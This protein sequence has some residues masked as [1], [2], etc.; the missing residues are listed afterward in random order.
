M[1]MTSTV[2]S[3]ASAL[4]IE[5]LDMIHEPVRHLMPIEAMLADPR[6]RHNSDARIGDEDLIGRGKR[7]ARQ[8]PRGH[9]NAERGALAQH[10]RSQDAGDAALVERW[11]G[12]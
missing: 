12:D 10:H 9:A 5:S 3:T 7:R 1:A 8:A 6:D 4:R 11:G 2:A